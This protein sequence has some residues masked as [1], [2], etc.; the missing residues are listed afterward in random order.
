[1]NEIDCSFCSDEVKKINTDLQW[2]MMGEV[3]LQTFMLM[4]YIHYLV[5]GKF[6]QRD[7]LLF[8]CWTF[9]VLI[10][11]KIRINNWLQ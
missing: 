10:M 7:D 3:F 1:M 8:A 9:T 4:I 6:D 2:C 5:F 11:M